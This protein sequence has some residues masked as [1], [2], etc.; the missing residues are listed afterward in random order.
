MVELELSL[1]TF[2]EKGLCRAGQMQSLIGN[3]QNYIFM[4]VIYE[5]YEQP[6]VVVID[7]EVEAGFATS[8]ILENPQ[9]EGGYQE[10]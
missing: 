2:A 6:Q 5:N 7:V 4:R 9:D 10:W 8:T 1:R 3:K